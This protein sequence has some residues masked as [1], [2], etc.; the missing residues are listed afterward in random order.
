MDEQAVGA[1][2]GLEATRTAELAE[3]VIGNL[4][5][6]I[7]APDETLQFSF[8]C[9]LAEGHLII[10]D[11]PG[12]GKT[13]LAKALARSIDCAFS[14]L[15]FTPDLLPSDVTGVNVFNQRSNEFE[16]R[17]GPVFANILLVDEINRASPKTQAALLECMQERQVTVDG[18]SYQLPPPFMV[19]ATQNPI[20]YEGTYPLPEAELDRF[21]M[22][23]AIGYPPLA[24]E[25]KMLS[26][27]ATDQPLDRLECVASAEELMEA[28]DDARRVFVEESL[29]RYVVTLLRQTRSDSRLYLGAS[30][31]A[32]IA[33]MRVAKARAIVSGRDYVEPDDV[34]TVAPIVLAHR[35]ILAPEAR[36]SG[37]DAEDLVRS[38]LE[39]TPVP[40]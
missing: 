3:R 28:I 12:V 4:Q 7:H 13:S 23:I 19:M 39:R 16:I 1:E 37:L 8:L 17:P 14:R 38:V 2:Q 6:V 21:T 29:N 11:F 26:V 24:D 32:G 31:R 9:L 22:R 35:L 40:V 36:S 15:Q 10:E 20:E 33:L 5:R 34:K 18:V 27:Q 25:A 30:P